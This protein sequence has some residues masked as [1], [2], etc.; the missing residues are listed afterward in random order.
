MGMRRDEFEA[1]L[2]ICKKCGKPKVRKRLSV[3]NPPKYCPDCLVKVRLGN[4]KR[5]REKREQVAEVPPIIVTAP[6]GFP[7]KLK[8]EAEQEYYEGRKGEYLKEFDW[9]ESS[10][11]SLL[12]R[13]LSLEIQ[14]RRHEN[15]D[16]PKEWET[17][18]YIDSIKEIQNLQ[19]RLGILR[20][21]RKKKKEERGPLDIVQDLIKRFNKYR[22]ENPDRFVWIC[23]KCGEKNYLKRENTDYAT[24]HYA[25]L[26]N[27]H[28]TPIIENTKI[29]VIEETGSTPILEESG[30]TPIEGGD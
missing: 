26:H 1:R 10:D 4:I 21:Q 5:A 24:L 3:R 15:N 22:E 18:L 12:S 25:E 20:L 11:L 13:L 6:D 28:S 29:E 27:E 19:Q 2:Y 8:N 23:S 7:L 9:A 14:C 17:R 30:A 16:K